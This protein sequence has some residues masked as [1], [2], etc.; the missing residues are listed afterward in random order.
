MKGVLDDVAVWDVALTAEE[1]FALYAPKFHPTDKR[2]I[3]AW[4]CGEITSTGGVRTVA[5]S[6]GNG[7]DLKLNTGVTATNGIVGGGLPN[8]HRHGASAQRMANAKL[9][10]FMVFPQ[11][12]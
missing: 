8:P 11:F 1:V 3:A 4:D 6:S 10:M 9:F 12:P 7:Y 5:D 2:L